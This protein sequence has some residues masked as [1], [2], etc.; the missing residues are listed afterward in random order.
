MTDKI[1]CKEFSKLIIPYLYDKLDKD[2]TELFEL[3][4]FSCNKCFTELKIAQHLNSGRVP[5]RPNVRQRTFLFRPA[6]VLSS[7]LLLLIFSTVIFIIEPS[8]NINQYYKISKF[9]PP[10]YVK[11]ETR[12]NYDYKFF[13]KA[14]V[15]YNNKN[16]KLALK[17]LNK[18]SSM[19]YKNYKI[20]FFKGICNLLNDKYEQAIDDFSIIISNMNPSYFDESIYYRGIAFL[21]MGKKEKAITELKNLSTDKYSPFSQKAVSLIKNIEKL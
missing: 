9:T 10:L 12:G 4:Y 3:H 15:Y 20:V 21:R 18:I 16:Y 19:K 5:I 7:L 11:A 1:E 8:K 6:F 2:D 13:D 14:M 17:E